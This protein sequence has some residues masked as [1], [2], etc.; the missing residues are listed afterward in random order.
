MTYRQG[1][2]RHTERPLRRL[3]DRYSENGMGRK[4][5]VLESVMMM[6]MMTTIITMT[7]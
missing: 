3:L 2:K 7:I 6:M 5:E 1:E 4:T